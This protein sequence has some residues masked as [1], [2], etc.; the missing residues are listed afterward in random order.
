MTQELSIRFAQERD[1]RIVC[2][3]GLAPVKELLSQEQEVFLVYDEQVSEAAG[4]LVELLPGIR[5]SFAI[6]AS[7]QEKRMET[8]LTLCRQLL[9]A[10][11]SRKAFL[12][13]L[14]GGVTTDLA[15]FAAAIYKRGIRYG[16]IPTTLLAQVDAAI[17]GKTGVNLDDY[18][19]MLG[20]FH[21]PAFTYLCADVL[22]SLPP[23]ERRSGLAELAKTLLLGDA[24]AYAELLENGLSAGLIYRAAA[25]KAAV[26]Q[27][28]PFEQGIRARLNLGHSFGHAIEH[29]A[30][31]E[32]G[33]I[34][35][36]EAVAMGILLA[37]ELSEQQGIAEK[38]LAARLKADFVRLGMPAEC[39]YPP[40]S[41]REALAKDKK[42]TGGKIRFV[43]P[44]KPGSV[45]LKDICL[46][47]LHFPTK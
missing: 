29:R 40:E 26:V 20:A 28:D 18:K 34:T 2:G 46:N 8:V 21:L 27:E 39:P 36:G 3:E 14:G 19:N 15:G 16:N 43:F 7:E 24:D 30:L 1:S 38:G 31:Q 11:A 4:A 45:V 33:D 23:R 10:D 37:A 41:L 35:H 9:E 32:G 12:L 17:G 22:R 5:G 6:D 44:E 47:D 13:A 25:I 42:A